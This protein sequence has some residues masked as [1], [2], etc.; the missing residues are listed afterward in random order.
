MKHEK[1]HNC[2]QYFI[3]HLARVLFFA[4][5]IFGARAET[6][7]IEISGA[8]SVS[9]MFIGDHIIYEL[10]VE[11]DKGFEVLQIEPP[12]ELGQFE[13]LDVKQAVEEKRKDGRFAKTQTFTL[14]TY[15]TGE[16]EIPAFKVFY[17][18]PQG[19]KKTGES[20]PIKIRVKPV[21]RTAEDKNDI[22]DLKSPLII[23]PKPYL[24]NFLLITGGALFL[25][26]LFAYIIY[27]KI[28]ARKLR[29]LAEET[30]K[31]PAWELAL[32]D[33][34]A[35]ENSLLISEKRFKEF[36]TQAADIVRIYLSSRYRI[37]AIDMTS[38][39]LLCALDD[40]N[41]DAAARSLLERMLNRC[42][43]VKFAKYIPQEAEHS[44]TL[45]EA[46]QIVRMTT[47]APEPQTAFETPQPALEG[48]AGS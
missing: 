13:I 16:F 4:L 15:E 8:A 19:E 48:G 46:R 23:A 7:P 17:Q 5:C 45:D 12:A 42:D 11:W 31:R 18:T 33:L 1:G 32:E 37:N 44:A 30:P 21:A 34:D 43:L 14:S 24:R 9:E 25:I 26:L 6:E 35:L 10:R 3:R 38:W 40:T 20:Q 47:P 41:M 39:E 29:W 27:R 28:Q 36:Y 22:R 2:F